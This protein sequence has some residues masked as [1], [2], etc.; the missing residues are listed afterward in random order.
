MIRILVDED[1]P[2]PTADLLRSL[3]IDAF[4]VREIGLK[5][6]TDQEIFKYAQKKGMIIISRDK[7]FSSIAK[8][9]LGTHSGIIVARLPYTFVRSQ[10]LSI[11]KKFFVDVEK[12][13]L[14]NNLTILEVGKYRIKTVTPVSQKD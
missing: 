8:Y 10:I 5:G 9:P 14:P 6:A 1:M 11:I 12:S 3:N 13:K 4:G 7:E 2:R